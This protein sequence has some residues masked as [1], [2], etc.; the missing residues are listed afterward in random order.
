MNLIAEI[1]LDANDVKRISWTSCIG[2]N[3]M[4]FRK[5]KSTENMDF[6]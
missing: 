4:Q 5:I 6:I 2:E 1:F 3:E